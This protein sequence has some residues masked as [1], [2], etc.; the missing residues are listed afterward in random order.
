[1]PLGVTAAYDPNRTFH[2]AQRVS[3]EQVPGLSKSDAD[4]GLR[5]GVMTAFARSVHEEMI[6]RVISRFL[7]ASCAAPA[8]SIP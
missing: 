7:P 1:V 8:A 6:V 5:Y 2:A 3:F 4:A